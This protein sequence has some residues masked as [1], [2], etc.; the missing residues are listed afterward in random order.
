MVGSTATVAVCAA[1]LALGEAI[2]RLAVFAAAFAI[3]GDASGA[4]VAC[5]K[6]GLAA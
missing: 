2:A 4:A 3:G 5:A 6:G 1:A